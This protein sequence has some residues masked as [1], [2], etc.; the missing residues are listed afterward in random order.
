[1]KSQKKSK[2]LITL[3]LAMLFVLGF[4]N[5]AYAYNLLSY[6]VN[7]PKSYSIELVATWNKHNYNTSLGNA[8]DAWNNSTAHILIWKTSEPSNEDAYI[9]IGDGYYGSNIGWDGLTIPG[10]TCA[11]PIVLINDSRTLNSDYSAY[12]HRTE[13]IAHELGH[14]LGLD[15]V[16]NDDTVLMLSSGYKGSA[17]PEKDDVKGVNAIY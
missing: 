1:M 6:Y 10:I 2:I 3:S 7:F 11:T 9:S 15:D 17:T 14:T 8:I 16:K 13:L 5:S 4:S 12:N